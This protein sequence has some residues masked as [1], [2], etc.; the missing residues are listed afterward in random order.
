LQELAL[1]YC[2]GLTAFLV[3]DLG[4]SSYTP[5]EISVFPCFIILVVNGDLSFLFSVIDFTA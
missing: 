2:L 3:F 1:D 5:E 4:H